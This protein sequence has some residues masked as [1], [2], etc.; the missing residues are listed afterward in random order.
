MLSEDRLC[1][2]LLPNWKVD[3]AFGSALIRDEPP[4]GNVVCSDTLDRQVSLTY[5]VLGKHIQYSEY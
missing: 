4:P 1:E 2:I 3:P 5:Y